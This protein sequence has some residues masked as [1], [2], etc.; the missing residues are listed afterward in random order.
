MACF[1][2]FVWLNEEPFSCE[3]MVVVGGVKAWEF[4]GGGA[5][6]DIIVNGRGAS[7]CWVE[8]T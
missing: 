7:L 2:P 5:E 8:V 3:G 1:V 6:E 4:W